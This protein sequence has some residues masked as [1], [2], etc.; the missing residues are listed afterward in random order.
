[1]AV[2]SLLVSVP[3]DAWTASSRMRCRME[4]VS[5]SA[6]SAVW[7]S[8]I[9]SCELRC[10]WAKPL[11]WPRS[12]SLMLKPAASSP[13]RLMRRPLDSFSTL[14]EYDIALSAMLRCAPNASTFV[15]IRVDMVL[16]GLLCLYVGAIPQH[17]AWIHLKHRH[18]RSAR[19]PQ[20][21]GSSLRG[22]DRRRASNRMPRRVR[23][24]F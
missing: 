8:E 14:F 19:S 16:V 18:R 3:L 9:P 5:F 12:F 4:C 2:W 22:G 6:P 7:M 1:M 24:N 17:R 15:L 11:I 20:T 21:G 10:A 13:A 23:R